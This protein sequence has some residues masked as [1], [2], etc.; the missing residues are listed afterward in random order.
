MRTLNAVGSS[1]K[2]P[3][4]AKV[5]ETETTLVGAVAAGGGQEGAATRGRVSVSH[6]AKSNGADDGFGRP[7]P[8]MYSVTSALHTYKWL[9]W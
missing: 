3:G 8:S 4:V 2:V 9:T 6:D 7:T 5:T 1:H